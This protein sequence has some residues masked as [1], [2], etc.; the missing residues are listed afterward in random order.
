MLSVFEMRVEGL[1]GL[2]I[3]QYG[4]RLLFSSRTHVSDGAPISE[5]IVPLNDV[6][7]KVLTQAKSA[8]GC[9][10]IGECS[11]DIRKERGE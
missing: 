4:S 10:R 9:D 2:S 8:P 1:L 6:R 11:S 7:S 3:A 5:V